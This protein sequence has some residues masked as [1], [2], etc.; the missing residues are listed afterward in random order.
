ML[1]RLR[2][3]GIYL[4]IAAFGLTLG[5][6]VVIHR[7]GESRQT[8][9]HS[10]AD[11]P[12]VMRMRKSSQLAITQKDISILRDRGVSLEPVESAALSLLAEA[13]LQ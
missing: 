12:A 3:W 2:K 4:S 11:D 8:S 1:R 5:L 7:H 13:R 10:I 6:A 9:L